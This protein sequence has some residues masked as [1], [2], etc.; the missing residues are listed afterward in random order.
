MTCIYVAISYSVPP[1]SVNTLAPP[2]PSHDGIH[3]GG[4]IVSVVQQIFTINLCSQQLIVCVRKQ[5]R[6]KVLPQNH[7]L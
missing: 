4:A 2:P 1:Q 5:F 3:D 7:K 6:K